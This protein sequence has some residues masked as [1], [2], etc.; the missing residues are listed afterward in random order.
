M[1]V[2]AHPDDLEYGAASAVA[3]WTAQGKQIAYVLVTR[4]EAGI[5]GMHPDQA[6][7]IREAEERASANAVGVTEIEFLDHADGVIEYGLPLRRDIAR[8]V[9]RRRPEILIS[10]NPHRS[11]GGSAWNS[12]DHRAVGRAVVDGARD[13][14]NRWVFPELAK[15][16]LEPWTGCRMVLF[17]GSPQPTHAVDV[18]DYLEHGIASLRC[19]QAYITGLGGD[20]DPDRFLRSGASFLGP[21]LGC[22]FA[23]SFELVPL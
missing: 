1:A 18:T 12:S 23:V 7:Q 21:S 9:R 11:W 13:G 2:V 8:E 22:E 10:L 6:R 20:F 4:G 16:G 5:D 15:E 19:H 14:A 17:N 3:R